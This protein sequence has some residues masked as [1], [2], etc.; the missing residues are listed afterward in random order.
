MRTMAGQWCEW[1]NRRQAKGSI[2]S[3]PW[4]LA[5]LIGLVG[6]VAEADDLHDAPEPDPDSTWTTF[7]SQAGWSVEYPRTWAPRSC[8]NCPDPSALGVFV[9][10]SEPA[11]DAVVLVQQLSNRPRGRSAQD[12]LREVE[13]SANLN[14]IVSE[15]SVAIGDLPARVVR[16]RNEA[17]DVDVETTYVVSD[18][19]TFSISLSGRRLDAL[20]GDL[21]A[22]EVYARIVASFTILDP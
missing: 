4:T 3:V 1:M 22:Q 5:V 21:T 20:L 17:A 6:C 19:N 2:S 16:Y 14:P 18:P 11:G 10:F 15:D 7:T 13:R 9:A 8:T 12:W